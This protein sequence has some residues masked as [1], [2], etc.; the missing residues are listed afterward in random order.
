[1]NLLL[2]SLLIFG[3]I[4]VLPFACIFYVFTSWSDRTLKV[5]TKKILKMRQKK[6]IEIFFQ[7]QRFLRQPCI[8]FLSHTIS[9]AI[10]II[11]IILSSLLF[12]AEFEKPF[13]RFS[14]ENRNL[15]LALNSSIELCRT[16]YQN[17]CQIYPMNNDFY[18]RPETPTWI[19]IVISI[20]VVGFF[21]HEIK[22]I[23][24]DGLK[25]YLLSWSNIMDSTMNVCY[26]VSFA[27]KYY[28]FFEV[29]H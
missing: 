7:F 3:Y 14:I 21:W 4:F 29:N 8:K 26:L 19:D 22:Q 27:L 2:I 16:V 28:V 10:F 12:A 23:M 17:S 6:R 11:L 20:F 15:S 13:K 24:I 1:M 18:F 5:K 9:Y 25:D